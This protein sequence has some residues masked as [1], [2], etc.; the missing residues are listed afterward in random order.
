MATSRTAATRGSRAARDHARYHAHLLSAS[1]WTTS[2]STSTAKAMPSSTASACSADAARLHG[3]RA[4]HHR[5]LYFESGELTRRGP[6]RVFYGRWSSEDIGWLRCK[7]ELKFGE[8]LHQPWPRRHVGAGCAFVVFDEDCTLDREA[9]RTNDVC[10]AGTTVVKLYAPLTLGRLAGRVVPARLREA[11][12]RRQCR[13][14]HVH[15][16]AGTW[17]RGARC[18]AARHCRRSA[19]PSPL[20][21]L[22]PHARCVQAFGTSRT[23]A[24]SRTCPCPRP[25]SS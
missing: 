20:P 21:G 24:A 19:T 10:E 9:F 14:H 4:R 25:R 2:R 17:L 15:Q 6:V 5:A 16:D 8:E 18:A 22:R 12:E 3:A 1:K 23:M 7:A 13:A 11:H